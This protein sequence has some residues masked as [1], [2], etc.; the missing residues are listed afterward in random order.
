MCI[1]SDKSEQDLSS[2]ICPGSITNDC[3]PCPPFFGY[4]KEHPVNSCYSVYFFLS[5]N[6]RGSLDL[7]EPTLRRTRNELGCDQVVESNYALDLTTLR[8]MDPTI[9]HTT[10]VLRNLNIV[11][12]Y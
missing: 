7:T 6:L 11:I 2:L 1:S 8:C 3:H 10:L 5:V 9:G 12:L 4:C